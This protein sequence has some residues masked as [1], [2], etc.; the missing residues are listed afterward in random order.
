M[1]IQVGF[2]K[3]EWKW[4][5]ENPRESRWH[6]LSVSYLCFFV[7]LLKSFSANWLICSSVHMIEQG[8][9]LLVYWFRH[10]ERHLSLSQSQFHGEGIMTQ[11]GSNAYP[12]RLDGQGYKVAAGDQIFGCGCVIMSSVHPMKKLH[13]ISL[14][15][16]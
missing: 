2:K 5:L 7:Y 6:M 8:P 12:V 9:S 1:G 15:L 11:F 14:G 13:C 4:E 16:Q 3:D 10:R